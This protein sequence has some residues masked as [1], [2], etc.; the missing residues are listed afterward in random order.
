[1]SM[2]TPHVRDLGRGY[3]ELSADFILALIA[4]GK[5]ATK[6]TQAKENKSPSTAR[7]V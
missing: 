6:A 4:I 7:T 2:D 3:V 1:M 5:P